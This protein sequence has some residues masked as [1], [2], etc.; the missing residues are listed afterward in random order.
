MSLLTNL[1]ENPRTDGEALVLRGRLAKETVTALSDEFSRRILASTI[2]EGKTVQEI[3]LEQAVPLST[4]YRR[5]HELLQEGLLVPER[6]VVTLE[7]KRHTVFR[8]SFKRVEVASDL[9]ETSVSVELNKDVAGKF[10][11]MLFRL[12]YQSVARPDGMARE[13]RA[14]VPRANPVDRVP[15][16]TR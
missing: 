15:T 8:S 4:C 10:Q 3:S 1:R 13:P 12:S 14:A 2:D 5:A 16:V 9:T 11:Q 6:I 7:G